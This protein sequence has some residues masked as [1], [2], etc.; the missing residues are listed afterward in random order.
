MKQISFFDL[1]EEDFICDTC[2]FDVNG[3]CSLSEPN[4]RY[5]I[6]GDS[7]IDINTPVEQMPRI[8]SK[9]IA[10]YIG[11]KFRVEF[12]E[13]ISE[14]GKYIARTKKHMILIFLDRYAEGV[15]NGEK[16]ISLS[17]DR[18]DKLGGFGSGYSTVKEVVNTIQNFEEEKGG[19][20]D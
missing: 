17:I 11:S 10:D 13:R 14:P 12:R 19:R 5:C 4:G 20:H 3:C 18:R 9:R 8:T 16:F 1:L 7:K 15:H 6:L 2:L